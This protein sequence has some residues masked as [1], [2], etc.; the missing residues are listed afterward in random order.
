VVDKLGEAD[1]QKPHSAKHPRFFAEVFGLLLRSG[2]SR[3]LDEPWI[4]AM[5]AVHQ[6][7]SPSSPAPG[8]PTMPAS[9]LPVGFG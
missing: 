7:N 3:P 8:A 9:T 4:A 2:K 5:S 6:I 1:E